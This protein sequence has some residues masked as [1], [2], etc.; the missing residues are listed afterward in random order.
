MADLAVTHPQKDSRLIGLLCALLGACL[1]AIALG[2]VAE[3]F[4]PFFSRVAIPDI[5]AI[6]L[7]VLLLLQGKLVVSLASLIYGLALVVSFLIAILAAPVLTARPITPITSFQEL[8]AL[9]MALV[10]VLIGASIAQ[11]PKL[12]RLLLIGLLIGVTWQSIIVVRDYLNP[13]QQ[14]FPDVMEGR[15]RST[16]RSAAQLGL[17]GYSTAGILLT[18]GWALFSSRRSRFWVL[19]CAFMAIFFVVVSSRRTALISLA[20]WCL[21]FLV[22]ALPAFNRREYKLTFAI[23]CIVG[24]VLLVNAQDLTETF[25]GQRLSSFFDAAF[26]GD[27]FVTVQLESAFAQVDLWFPFGLGVGR[28][29]IVDPET[30]YE[31]HNAHLAL[32]VELGLLGLLSFYWLMARCVFRKWKQAFRSHTPI[33]R[34]A[35]ISFVVAV[36]VGMIHLSLHRDRAFGLFLGIAPLVALTIVDTTDKKPTHD[37]DRPASLQR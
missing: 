25:F 34:A 19:V 4:H 37:H 7:I 17:Y 28:G 3:G 32:A 6:T 1:P 31:L 11:S 27:N 24:A 20:V 14:W 21:S 8:L 5:F 22:L 36:F 33:I 9:F 2:S 30:Y 23:T 10:Y 18:F 29:Q 13:A 26:Q 12:V 16:F 15:V 35:T